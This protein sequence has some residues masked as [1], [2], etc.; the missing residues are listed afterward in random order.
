GTDR[1]AQAFPWH[2]LQSSG[3]LLIFGTDYPVGGLA[4]DPITGMFCAIKR[5]FADGTPF[6]SEQAVD[7][8]TAL[9]AYTINPAHAIG[10]DDRIGKVAVGYQA[11]LVIF[12]QDPKLAA[13]QSLRSNAPT[14]VMIA[15]V[16]QTR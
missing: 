6:H 2:D 11:D 9:A 12:P 7:A 3:A 13:A 5:E 15:G 1:L 16:A 4:E 8:A 10:W 14:L